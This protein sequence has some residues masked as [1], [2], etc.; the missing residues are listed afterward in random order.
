MQRL[1]QEE[2]LWLLRMDNIP[3]QCI[4]AIRESSQES[5]IASAA[6]RLGWQVIYRAT[7]ARDLAAFIEEHPSAVL[8]ASDDFLDIGSV[9][10]RYKLTF[11]TR[12]NDSSSQSIELSQSDGELQEKVLALLHRSDR[13][14]RKT[15]AMQS[16]VICFASIGRRLGLTTFATNYAAEIAHLGHKVLLVDANLANPTISYNLNIHGLRKSIVALDNNLSLSEL[17]SRE[18]FDAIVEESG[19]HEFI[20]IDLGEINLSDYV[21]VGRRLRDLITMTSIKSAMRC[22]IFVEEKEF[23]LQR[24]HTQLNQL[25]KF[26]ADLTVEVSIFS[27]FALPPKRRNAISGEIERTTGLQVFSIT[28]DNRAFSLQEESRK[29]LMSCAPKSLL[30][31]QIQR[32]SLDHL[33]SMGKGMA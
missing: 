18:M 17:S 8:I 31:R 6:I 12:S 29:L 13:D 30:R 26:S 7:L 20:V 15:A 4:T 24:L 22:N 3:I 2:L 11:R 28:R 32:Y 14:Y 19:N 1:R 33:E 23:S 5:A 21:L 25:R 27:D 9:D 16:K 10:A